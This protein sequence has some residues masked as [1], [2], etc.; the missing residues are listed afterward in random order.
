MVNRKRHHKK[1]MFSSIVVLLF[2]ACL[3]VLEW[4]SSSLSASAESSVFDTPGSTP[5]ETG[6]SAHDIPIGERLPW[7]TVLPF[8]GILLSIALFPLIAPHLWH[9]H[10]PKVSLFWATIFAVPFLLSHG[11]VAMEKIV[12]IFVIDYIPFIVL[13]WALFTIAGGIHIRGTRPGTPMVNAVI[14]LIGTGLASLIGTTGA[15]MLLIRPLLRFNSRR[16]YRAHTIVFYIFL[17][18]NIGG[19]LTPLGDPPLFLGF[20][21]GVPF[22]WT[23][24]LMPHLVFATVVLLAI[25]ILLDL[26]YYR[27][28]STQAKADSPQEKVPLGIDG[29]HNFL[30]LLGV[31][32]AVLFSG[33]FQRT[34]GDFAVFPEV[35]VST[36]NMVEILLLIILGIRS[37]RT[38]ATEHRERNEYSTAPIKEVAYLFAGIFMTIIPAIAIL[39][40][41]EKGAFSFL[42]KAVDRPADYFWATG[43]LS[44]FL[45]NAPTYLTFFNT[46]LGKF[47]AGIPEPDAVRILTTEKV[48]YLAAISVGAVFMGAI[49]YI[50]NAPNFM[51]K[52]IAEEAGIKMPSF[53]GFILKYSIP[54]LI[55]LFIVM[56]FVFF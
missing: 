54:Y 42:I 29:A 11:M 45:D 32:A 27:L 8:A 53:F 19:T 48:S 24:R 3:T 51:V 47:Y 46:A 20:L 26:Y 1:K 37:L 18:S 7:W 41:G 17:V 56:T 5:G 35:R 13:L 30:Y 14:L 15:S 40:A 4:P 50:G 33:L 25:Y 12:H 39:Q 55:I 28:E 16:R 6:S 34:I 9:H 44:G 49:S 36:A 52:S 38:T 23:F 22:T 10:Y 21:H 31:V 43:L 2:L